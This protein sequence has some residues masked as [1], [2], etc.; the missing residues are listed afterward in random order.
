MA[1][2]FYKPFLIFRFS[3][4]FL[5]S[6]E[7]MSRFT[8]EPSLYYPCI[9]QSGQR[10][11]EKYKMK[12]GCWDMCHDMPPRGLRGACILR[13]RHRTG[14]RALCEIRRLRT[15]IHLRLRTW[16]VIVKWVWSL[17]CSERCFLADLFPVL[18]RIQGEW[19]FLFEFMLWLCTF[20]LYVVGCLSSIDLTRTTSVW[21]LVHSSFCM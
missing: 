19:F 14:N 21:K 5:Y 13:D 2:I 16:I 9:G 6:V 12:P 7:S 10:L 18:M 17:L 8:V 15:Y 3:V 1:K 4:V 11:P 20:T